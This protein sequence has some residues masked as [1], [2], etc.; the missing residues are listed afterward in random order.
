MATSTVSRLEARLRCPTCGS[1]LE[2]ATARVQC[3]SEVDHSFALRCHYPV[4]AP[5]ISQGKYDENYA[6]RYAFLWAYGFEARHSGLV[7][8]LY[9]TVSSLAAEHAAVLPPSSLIVD[10]G[11]GTGRGTADLARL[12][13]NDTALLGVDASFAKL[14]LAADILMGTAPIEATFPEYG[15]DKPLTIRPRGLSNVMLVQG[16]ARRLPLADASVDLMLCVN[17]LDRVETGP[18]AALE[19]ARRVIR[20]EGGLVLTTPMNWVSTEVWR[21]Y[22]DS[23][24]LLALIE[25][26]GFHVRTWFDQLLYREVIDRRG[27]VEEFSTFVCSAVREIGDA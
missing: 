26:C 23:A 19:E 25:D 15:F 20:P 7:E 11:C 17:L 16:D 21:A 22:P 3:T 27:S 18:R 24:A 10:C 9:R 12:V 5:E 6:S 4:F 8:S 14:D 2:W 13:S 1:P